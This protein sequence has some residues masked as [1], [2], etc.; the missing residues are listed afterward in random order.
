[1]ESKIFFI[2]H[3]ITVGNLNSWY[4]GA[5]DLPLAQEGIDKVTRMAAAGCYPE[6]AEDAGYYTTGLIRTEHTLELVVGPREH[7]QIPKL[8][9]MRFGEYE[10]KGFE[11]L[12]DDPVFLEWGYDKTGDVALPGAETLNQFKNRIKEGLDEL[13]GYHRLTELAH[14]HDGNPAH[15]VMFCHGGVISAIMTHLFPE[16]NC[17][18]WD[19]MPDPGEGYIVTFENSDPVSYEKIVDTTVESKK[20]EDLSFDGLLPD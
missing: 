12:K 1:M 10:C 11:E 14:R 8:Q 16:D 6:F 3:G 7:R 13:I 20:E 9:E 15:S 17:T 2:R 18:T 4:Y 19:W 5:T